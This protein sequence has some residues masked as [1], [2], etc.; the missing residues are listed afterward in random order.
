MSI[1][2][3]LKNL[4]ENRADFI[5]ALSQASHLIGHAMD[6]LDPSDRHNFLMANLDFFK[7]CDA[8]DRILAECEGDDDV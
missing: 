5:E 4:G 6:L 7:A 8:F 1:T 2:R 3:I